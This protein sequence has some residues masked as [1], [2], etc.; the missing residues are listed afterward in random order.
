MKFELENA[1]NLHQFFIQYYN[2]TDVQSQQKFWMLSA[3][4]RILESAIDTRLEDGQTP[5][6]VAKCSQVFIDLLR[7]EGAKVL[8]QLSI[9]QFGKIFVLLLKLDN[10][11]PD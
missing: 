8:T 1:G 5:V 11:Q 10:V 3:I 2:F 7:Q 9:P 6:D 4:C